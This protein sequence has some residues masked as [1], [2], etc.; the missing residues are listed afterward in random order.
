M[1]QLW[2]QLKLKSVADMVGNE[3]ALASLK[4]T[5][6]GLFLFSGPMGTGKTS[7]ALALCKERTGVTLEE[8]Q[9]VCNMGRVY[10]QHCHALDFDLGTALEPKFFFHMRDTVFIIVDEADCMTNVRQQTRLKT[11]PS[12]PDLTL[13]FCTANPEKLDPA[14]VDRC[15]QVRLGPL[16]AM[17]VPVLVKRACLARG[18]PYDAEIV[19]S[20]NRSEIFRPRAILQ[21]IDAI[22]AGKSIAE[23]VSGQRR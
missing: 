21:A 6:N 19:K 23:A 16:P 4:A 14:V 10:A 8:N 3:N 13:V 9:C 20:L 2:Q 7:L 5:P 18:I 12:R 1:Q 15:T 11:L 17:Q 22:A